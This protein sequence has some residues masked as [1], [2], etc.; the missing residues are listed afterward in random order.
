MKM[1]THIQIPKCVL[2]N[3]RNENNL[4]FY[5]DFKN[6]AIVQ[7]SPKNINIDYNYFSNDVEKFLN[8]EFETK[9]GNLIQWLKTEY[10]NQ[11]ICLKDADFKKYVDIIKKYAYSLIIRSPLFSSEI[12]NSLIF[13]FCYTDQQIND[14]SICEGYKAA[15]Q[16]D[17]LKNFYF[18]IIYIKEECEFILPMDGMCAYEIGQKDMNIV[19]FLSPKIA[20]LF[21]NSFCRNNIVNASIESV[22]KINKLAFLQQKKRGYGFVV[23]SKQE[24]IEKNIR[25]V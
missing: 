9:L 20:I 19:I 3:F 1:K 22:E 12:R 5:Y 6:E 24:T 16:E 13:S 17:F 8:Q 18:N 23:A 25:G 10:K 4:V 11:T 7:K 14:F 2:K 15:Q 21:S